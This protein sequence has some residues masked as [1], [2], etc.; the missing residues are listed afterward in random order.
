M[1]DQI[2]EI[3]KTHTDFCKDI[4][5]S[6]YIQKNIC[7][8]EEHNDLTDMITISLNDENYQLLPVSENLFI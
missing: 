8:T 3:S 7:K 5:E 1:L 2:L 4:E 6:S